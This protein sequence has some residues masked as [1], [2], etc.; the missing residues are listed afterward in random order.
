M[1]VID[2]SDLWHASLREER[3]LPGGGSRVSYHW[4]G[5][6]GHLEATPLLILPHLKLIAYDTVIAQPLQIR[7]APSHQ[8]GDIWIDITVMLRGGCSHVYP[9]L[10]C[11]LPLAT[12]DLNLFYT[13]D[14]LPGVELHQPGVQR[15]LSLLIQP[16]W[17]H[18]YVMAP[19]AEHADLWHGLFDRAPSHPV[20]RA[21]R[22]TT[23]IT[24]LLAQ[25]EHCPFDGPLRHIYLEAKALELLTLALDLIAVHPTVCQCSTTP[26]RRDD[27]ER[28]RH[29][30]DL[31]L[32]DVANPPSLLALARHV[33]INDHKLKRGFRELF[34]TTVFGYLRAQRMEVAQHLLQQRHLSVGEVAQSVGYIN[35]SKFAAAYRRH[36]GRSPKSSAVEHKTS[37]VE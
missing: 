2:F 13:P 36:F 31:L 8:S 5:K 7:F 12:G 15:C 25:I 17:L 16:M 24:G 28:I 29:A 6:L 1:I 21:Q 14:G 3:S 10:G 11:S 20:A 32:A 18:R 27:A 30:R 33:G 35:A 23:A 34:G 37:V 22:V 26:L 9:E 19:R 4:P